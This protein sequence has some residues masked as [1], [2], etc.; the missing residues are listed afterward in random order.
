MSLASCE[1]LATNLTNEVLPSVDRDHDQH[2]H[3]LPIKSTNGRNLVSPITAIIRAIQAIR[4]TN[5]EGF[6]QLVTFLE[7][8]G[9]FLIV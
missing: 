7:G 9:Y 8:L 5:D 6:L 4:I 3:L 1:S 2:V